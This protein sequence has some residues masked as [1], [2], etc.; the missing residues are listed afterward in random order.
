MDRNLISQRQ[1]DAL[2]LEALRAYF[3]FRG[4]RPTA[5]SVADKLVIPV[6]TVREWFANPGTGHT[7]QAGPG[8]HLRAGIPCEIFR[9]LKDKDIRQFGG[10]RTQRPVLAGRLNS[11]ALNP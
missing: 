10:Y 3:D 6:R 8:R 1:I 5:E 2:K 11:R 9:V 4:G 7:V